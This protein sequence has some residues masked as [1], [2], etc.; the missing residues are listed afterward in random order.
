MFDA[1][2]NAIKTSEV[3]AFKTTAICMHVC[4][5]N[6]YYIYLLHYYYIKNYKHNTL[7]GQLSANVL[8]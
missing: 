1:V 3:T 8:L 6:V 4:Y 5:E 2:Y 7:F